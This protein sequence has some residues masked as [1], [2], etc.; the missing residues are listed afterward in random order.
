MMTK[1]RKTANLRRTANRLLWLSLL[2]CGFMLPAWAQPS[3]GAALSQSEILIGDQVTLTI[4]AS[5][6]PPVEVKSIGFEVLNQE[7]KLE[8]ISARRFEKEGENGLRIAEVEIKLTSFDSGYYLI[9][10]IPIAYEQNGQQA[11][12]RTNGLALS[13]NTIPVSP[14]A[15]QIQPIKGIIE[16]PVNFRDV[17][18][19]LIGAVLLFALVGGLLFYFLRRKRPEPPPPPPRKVL[20]HILALEQLEALGQQKLWQ[21]GQVKRYHSELTHILR[22]YLERR[23]GIKAMERT[24]EEILRELEQAGMEATYRSQLQQLLR[25]VDLVKFAKAEPPPTFHAE[26][27]EKVSG[28][29]EQTKDEALEVELPPDNGFK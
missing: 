11:T 2:L 25:T 19:Y 24:T 3:V 28:F 1:S 18:P 22:A 14:D 29:V 27:M 4:T 17:L 16:E 23:Y 21:Q 10:P 9:P 5:Y 13:V 8:V 12:I 20:A 6:S 15:K 7:P 26:A